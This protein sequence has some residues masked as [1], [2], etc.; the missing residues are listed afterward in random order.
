MWVPSD[1]HCP[2][3]L[4]VPLQLRELDRRPL[5]VRA[6]VYRI[7][8][9]FFQQFCHSNWCQVVWFSPSLAKFVF[10]RNFPAR[11]DSAQE[12]V[13][14][15][16]GDDE[17]LNIAI[18]VSLQEEAGENIHNGKKVIDNKKTNFQLAQRR[19]R[20]TMKMTTRRCWRWPLPC[21]WRSSS[22]RSTKPSTWNNKTKDKS[23]NCWAKNNVKI[24]VLGH[25]YIREI[26]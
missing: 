19:H 15:R 4:Q 11:S 6:W 9:F 26:T 7:S 17:M 20:M 14:N 18:A 16:D 21:P 25:W 13:P 12:Q 22:G 5:Q 3:H 1:F 2:Q 24:K 10:S 8:A 23:V